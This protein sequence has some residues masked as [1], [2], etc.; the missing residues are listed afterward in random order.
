M[1]IRMT[2]RTQRKPAPRRPA[3]RC[4]VAAPSARR[5]REPRLL[6]FCR[7][8]AGPIFVLVLFAGGAH[9]IFGDHGFL[10]K[11]RL[12]KEVETIQPEIQNL[13]LDNQRLSGQI[14]DLKSDPRLIERIAR[15]EMGLARPGELVFKLPENR[16]E[17]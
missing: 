6:D 16:E 3:Q 10:A 11:H 7:R 14:R 4:R 1:D 15:E 13:N 17:E 2:R 9:V 12:N 5:R 8:W